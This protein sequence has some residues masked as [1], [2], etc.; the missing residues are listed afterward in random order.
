MTLGP[1]FQK[2]E[3]DAVSH[4]QGDAA[5]WAALDSIGSHS[6]GMA[7]SDAWANATDMIK[8]YWVTEVG[9]FD[10]I[11][12]PMVFPGGGGEFQGVALAAR[13]LNDLNHMVD[14]WIWFIGAWI[15]DTQM[16]GGKTNCEKGCGAKCGD[17]DC[18]IT[19]Q[20]DMKL[21]STCPTLAEKAGKPCYDGNKSA[22]FQLMP[23]YHYAKQLRAAFD[24]GCSMRYSTVNT[25]SLRYVE[26]VPLS[27]E[28]I[29]VF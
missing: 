21:I 10:G 3:R 12:T 2:I 14:T 17:I 26:T 11:D 28:L 27:F 29:E 4:P 19:R 15:L 23:Q 20:E 13:F 25:T 9:A 6:Y 16:L 5:C 1:Q 7:A 22:Y 8:G 24:L 18:G